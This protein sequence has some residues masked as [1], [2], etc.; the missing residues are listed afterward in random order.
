MFPSCTAPTRRDGSMPHHVGRGRSPPRMGTIGTRPR[1]RPNYAS[2]STRVRKGEHPRF[3]PGMAF[4]PPVPPSV[5]FDPRK[6]AVPI[7]SLTISRRPCLDR[8]L[9]WI[10]PC[11]LHHRPSHNVWR[12]DNATMSAGLRGTTTAGDGRFADKESRM[13]KQSK[14]PKEFA[15]QVDVSRVQ[16]DRMERWVH[17]RLEQLLG[18]EDE[19][20]TAY[21]R[22]MLEQEVRERYDA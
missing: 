8:C 22:T 16:L 7:R 5:G 11:R 14:F 3:E 10:G 18:E 15:R 20:L 9:S 2:G 13:M 12:L 4:H 21:V 19:V 6:T 17:Q 1:A